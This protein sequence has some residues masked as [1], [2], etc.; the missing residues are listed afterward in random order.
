MSNFN[1]SYLGLLAQGI[2]TYDL[3]SPTNISSLSISGYFVSNI[4]K[5]D[6]LTANCFIS[7]GYSGSNTIV[8]GLSGDSAFNYDVVDPNTSGNLLGDPEANI[9]RQIYIIQ[10][11][12]GLLQ[13]FSGP[14]LFVGVGAAGNLP[15]QAN[16]PVQMMKEG[17]SV[18]QWVNVP[19]I[20]ATYQKT[21]DSKRKE[22]NYLVE[23]Y[24]IQSQGSSIPRT[25]AFFNRVSPNPGESYNSYMN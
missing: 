10:Y 8:Y 12:E 3:N 14:G 5:F 7:F 17:D 18:I 24:N 23:S 13:S 4:G 16:L 15:A 6:N 22:L 20:L 25:L 11:Y 9:L 1:A 19:A 2:W 21:L